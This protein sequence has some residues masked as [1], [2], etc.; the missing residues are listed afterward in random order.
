VNYPFKV[1]YVHSLLKQVFT[2]YQNSQCVKCFNM[3]WVYHMGMGMC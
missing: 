1:H 2:H 3:V